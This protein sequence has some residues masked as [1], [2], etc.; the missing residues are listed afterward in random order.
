MSYLDEL[1]VR[2]RDEVPESH[3]GETSLALFRLYAVLAL[4]KGEAV[5]ASDVHNAWAAWMQDREPNHE[6]LRPFD[7]L[8]RETREA[9]SPFVVAIRAVASA[10]GLDK[11]NG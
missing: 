8:D 1:A 10:G 11:P 4:A 5:E 6:A 2:I 7:E 3:R 9:D